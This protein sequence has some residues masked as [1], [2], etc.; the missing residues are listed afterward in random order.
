MVLHPPVEPAA[1]TGHLKFRG[2]PE[3][4]SR[5]REPRLTRFDFSALEVWIVLAD[6]AGYTRGTRQADREEPNG[7]SYAT[8]GTISFRGGLVDDPLFRDGANNERRRGIV[9]SKDR[10]WHRIIASCTSSNGR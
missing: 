4:G 3:R 7:E 9:F 2:S 10:T 6:F 8:C 5:N 1:L